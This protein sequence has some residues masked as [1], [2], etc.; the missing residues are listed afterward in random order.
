MDDVS[1]NGGATG[2]LVVDPT[3]ISLGD[4]AGATA[5]ITVTSTGDWKATVSGSGFSID[6]TTGTA[7]DT[8]ITVTA[9]EANASSEIKIWVR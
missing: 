8:S 1:F 7:S 9:S 3:A 5:K 2:S 6:K 4:A